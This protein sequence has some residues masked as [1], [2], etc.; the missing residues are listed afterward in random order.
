MDDARKKSTVKLI[1]RIDLQALAEK[2]VMIFFYLGQALFSNGRIFPIF[3]GGRNYLTHN[4]SF[5]T[6]KIGEVETAH[7]VNLILILFSLL[8]F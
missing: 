6:K 2:Y 1:P 5:S 3:Y 7:F 4:F 8:Y